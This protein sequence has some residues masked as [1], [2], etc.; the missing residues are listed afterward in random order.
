M[1]GEMEEYV[2][3]VLAE[4]GRIRD[5]LLGPG[6][7][8][9]QLALGGGTPTALPPALMSRLVEGISRAFS[10]HPEGERSVEVDPRRV[11][12]SYLDLLLDLGFNRFSLGVQD[13]D[14]DVQRLVNR[15]LDPAHLEGLL[16]H[17]RSRGMHAVNLDL[18]YGL[19]GQTPERFG[20]T[21]ARVAAL[22]PS[23]V[24]VFGYAHVPWVSPHQ[25]ALERYAMPTPDERMALFGQAWEL[26]R[27]EGYVHLGMDHFALPEDELVRAHES[28]TLTRNFMGYTTR[29]GLDLAG[30]GVSAISSVGASYAQNVKEIPDYRLGGGA[31]AW[32]RGLLLSREDE[33]RRDLI[34][35][36][37]CNFHLDLRRFETRW[38]IMFSSHFA[39]ELA[40]LE[41][42]VQDGLVEVDGGELRVTGVGRF[43]IRNVC[44]VFDEYL[45]RGSREGRYSKTL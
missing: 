2:D 36:L 16:T 15:V 30:L 5:T 26:L 19:P 9:E 24:A 12:A 29:R 25:K 41:L 42:L 4:A 44:M 37:F 11:D 43:F 10:F 40:A 7:P 33:L 45:S 38:G 1:P 17:L 20:R 32:A 39:R 14:P 13:L 18:I 23:R 21:L 8:L 27:Q 28:R 3:L 31:P 22:R 35:D 6:R 34:L